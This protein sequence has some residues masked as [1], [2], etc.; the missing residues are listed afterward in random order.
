[1]RGTSEKRENKK[2]RGKSR[3]KSKA[4]RKCF[5]CHK[6]GH[7]KRNRLERNNKNPE[8]KVD[9]GDALVVT[10]EIAHALSIANEKC[11][12]IWGFFF[13]FTLDI[14]FI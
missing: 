2:R 13:F 4:I 12:D 1:M 14:H 3:S 10:N 5:K 11:K 8:K 7:S 6:E 9:H